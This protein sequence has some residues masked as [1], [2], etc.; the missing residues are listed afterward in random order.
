VK[1]TVP[2]YDAKMQDIYTTRAE[3]PQRY[4]MHCGLCARVMFQTVDEMTHTRVCDRCRPSPPRP[5]ALTDDEHEAA[6]RAHA[7]RPP[8]VRAP[9]VRPPGI[10]R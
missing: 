7:D 1:Y 4:R 5:R 9:D 6:A 8:G 3:A 10:K 2:D